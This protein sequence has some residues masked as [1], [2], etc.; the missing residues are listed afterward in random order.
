MMDD[1]KRWGGLVVA[2]H[3]QTHF[4]STQPWLR[5]PSLIPSLSLFSCSLMNFGSLPPHC[6]QCICTPIQ[7]LLIIHYCDRFYSWSI[8]FFTVIH[9]QC[10][11]LIGLFTQLYFSLE[12]SLFTLWFN[13]CVLHL[14]CHLP[15]YQSCSLLPPGPSLR[16]FP[17]CLNSIHHFFC[18]CSLAM[19][20]GSRDINVRTVCQLFSPP[21]WSEFKHI[22]NSYYRLP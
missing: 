18:I 12:F 4:T 10:P 7:I 20:G 8:F 2:V 19:Q 9:S 15:S 6:L 5:N 3:A 11:Y 21:V 17:L 22:R 1:I 13:S 14:I 16:S